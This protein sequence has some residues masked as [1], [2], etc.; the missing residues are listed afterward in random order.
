MI[1]TCSHPGCE[2]L[3]L[4]ALCIEHETPVDRSFPRGR[5]FAGLDADDGSTLPAVAA[6]AA[7][8]A[9]IIAAVAATRAA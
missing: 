2:T 4:G 1:R 5:P 7:D 3:T 9:A 8:P 6:H